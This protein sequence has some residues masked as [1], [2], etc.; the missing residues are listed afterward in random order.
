[1]NDQ[2]IEVRS[3]LLVIERLQNICKVFPLLVQWEIQV[4]I[5]FGESKFLAFPNQ[6]QNQKF[7]NK[8]NSSYCGWGTRG[9]RFHNSQGRGTKFLTHYR[10][11]NHII[12]SCFKKHDFP[13]NWKKDISINDFSDV[14]GKIDES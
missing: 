13:P 6:N 5:P 11:T 3:P 9:G 10:V 8:G 14:E 2:Y 12:D 1:M 4:F 7:Q